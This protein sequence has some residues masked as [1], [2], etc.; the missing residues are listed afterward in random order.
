MDN[1]LTAIDK[2]SIDEILEYKFKKLLNNVDNGKKNN[3][4][5]YQIILEIFEKSLFKE[6]I[7]AT[8]FNQSKAS[9]ILGINRNTLKKKLLKYNLID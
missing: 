7:E 9:E 8:N 6:V 5:L 2:F 1:D 4:N 3:H